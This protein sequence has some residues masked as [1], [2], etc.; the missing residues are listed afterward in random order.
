VEREHISHILRMTSR[1]SNA[2]WNEIDLAA[3]TAQDRIDGNRVCPATRMEGGWR[4]S[5]PEKPRDMRR[6]ATWKHHSHFSA[7]GRR[8]WCRRG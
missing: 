4:R 6:L 8:D 1:L 3:T 2:R 5:R 7:R